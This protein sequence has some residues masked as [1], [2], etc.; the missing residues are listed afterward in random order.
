M[1]TRETI[2][3]K[4]EI[5]EFKVI[6]IRFAIY[7]IEDNKRLSQAE[8]HRLSY[9]PGEIIPIELKEID[10]ISKIIWTE[11]VIKKYNDMVEAA[12]KRTSEVKQ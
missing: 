1:I 6:Q 12:L 4:I 11:D 10:D 5:T 2:I 3:D 7:Y 9:T 8:Y